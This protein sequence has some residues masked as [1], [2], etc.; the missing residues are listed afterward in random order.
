MAQHLEL[1]VKRDFAPGWKHMVEKMKLFFEK[2]SEVDPKENTEETDW[3]DRAA[4]NWYY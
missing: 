1:V 2:T 3:R 4:K